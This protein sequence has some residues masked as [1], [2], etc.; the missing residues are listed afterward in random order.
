VQEAYEALSG[1]GIEFT[2]EPRNVTGAQWAANFEDPDGHRLSIF[3]PEH[4]TH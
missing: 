2:H 1:K 4:E 3:G